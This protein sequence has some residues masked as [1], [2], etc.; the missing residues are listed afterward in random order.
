MK[1]KVCGLKVPGNIKAVAALNPDY[2]GFIF[3]GPSPRFINGLT[4]DALSQVPSYINKTAVFVNESKEKVSELI[5]QYHFDA[6]QLHGDETPDF[7][8][9]F[10][11]KVTVLK[12]FGVNEDFDFSRLDEFKNSVDFFLFDTKTPM[13]GGSGKTF[14]WN[15]LD[16]YKLEIPF[17]LSG[18]LSLENIEEVKNICHPQFY[19]VDLN[20]KFEIEP[21]IKDISKLAKAFDIIKQKPIN[22]LRS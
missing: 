18:G 20:S 9:Y 17:F 4:L 1:I 5:D 6:I 19:G 16:G 15:I 21:G 14:N 11:G 8:G 22:E 10:K 12:A 13:H 3:Y 2:A 7:A